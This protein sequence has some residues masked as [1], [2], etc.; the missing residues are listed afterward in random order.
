MLDFISCIHRSPT[1]N[2]PDPALIVK[3]ADEHAATA[4]KYRLN[5]S[6]GLAKAHELKA[7]ENAL[8]QQRKAETITIETQLF[9][10]AV[11]AATA[12]KVSYFLWFYWHDFFH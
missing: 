10:F 8:K 6:G 12:K 2:G 1:D 5:Q 11:G 4:S 9:M 7:K 3:R